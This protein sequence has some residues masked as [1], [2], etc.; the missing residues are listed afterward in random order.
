MNLKERE[1]LSGAWWSKAG[2]NPTVTARTLWL[3][4]RPLPT[5]S[6]GIGIGGTTRFPARRLQ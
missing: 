3:E 6:D 1:F 5:T 2:I 4:T